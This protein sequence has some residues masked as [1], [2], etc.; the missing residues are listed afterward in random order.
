MEDKILEKYYIVT[1]KK[2]LDSIKEDK[3]NNRSRNEFIKKFYT[4]N[5]ID[6]EEYYFGGNGACNRP[7]IESE[8]DNINLHINDTENNRKRYGKQFAKSRFKGMV[9]LR[10][11]SKLLKLFQS[12]C[13]EKDIVVNLF[14]TRPG[15]YF[16]ELSLGGY[17]TRLFTFDDR[18]YLRISTDSYQNRTI[19]PKYDGFEEIKA[20]EFFTAL[21]QLEKVK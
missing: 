14:E 7:F 15:E 16:D 21:E 5:N 20:S 17:S 9:K 11:K 1:N 18:I 10:K 12:A 8:K 19:T 2:F 13:I 3:V 6:G 4:D